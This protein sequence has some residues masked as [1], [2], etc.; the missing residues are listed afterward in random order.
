MIIT[1]SIGLSVLAFFH[2]QTRALSKAL[3][4][5]CVGGVIHCMGD[6]QDIRFMGGLS[7]YIPF[8]SSSSMVSNFAVCGLPFLAGLYS[9]DFILEMFSVRYVNIFGLCRA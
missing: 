8:T 2:L 4:R 5:M 6:S 3:L 1:I 7:I 9:K